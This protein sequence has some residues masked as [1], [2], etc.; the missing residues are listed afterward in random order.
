MTDKEKIRR[1]TVM[2]EHVQL[3]NEIMFQLHGFRVLQKENAHITKVLN[4]TKE[5]TNENQIP[6]N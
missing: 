3:V 6:E 2:L 5:K 1:L 4:I